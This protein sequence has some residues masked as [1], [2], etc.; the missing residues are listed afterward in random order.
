M[1]WPD[2]SLI[3]VMDEG[4]YSCYNV[5]APSLLLLGNFTDPKSNSLSLTRHSIINQADRK[6]TPWKI[7]RAHV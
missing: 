6:S 3:T 2:D 4:K 5:F 1:V 7:G